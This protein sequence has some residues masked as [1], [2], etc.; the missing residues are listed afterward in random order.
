MAASPCGGSCAGSI[1]LENRAHKKSR[2][3]QGRLRMGLL[4][5]PSGLWEEGALHMGEEWANCYCPARP[6]ATAT[7]R[8]AMGL[9][10]YRTS[11][12]GWITVCHY[13]ILSHCI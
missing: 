8:D 13:L 7:E 6:T 12:S 2:P 9:C 10:N 11:P 3:G 5:S 4:K 1:R